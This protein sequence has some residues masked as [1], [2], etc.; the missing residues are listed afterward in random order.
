MNPSRL[1]PLLLAGCTFND[2][3]LPEK[4]KA[5][6]ETE[7]SA[8]EISCD[9]WNGTFDKAVNDARVCIGEDVRILCQNVGYG[10][11]HILTIKT[12]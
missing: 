5:R 1:A 8:L 10:E 6:C 3:D 7:L 12:L 2:V 9:A 11:P 4:I